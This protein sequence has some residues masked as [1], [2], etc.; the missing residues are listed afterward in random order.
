MCRQDGRATI[1]EIEDYRLVLRDNHWY[2]DGYCLGR[3]AFRMFRL[4]R[5]AHLITQESRFVSRTE[6]TVEPFTETMRKRQ[7]SIM[8]RIDAFIQDRVMDFCSSDHFTKEGEMHYLVHC[9]FIDDDYGYSILLSFGHLC[10]C[11]DPPAIR[12]ELIRRVGKQ[13]EI[14][15]Q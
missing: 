6:D 10:E 7:A 14:Y 15:A 13:Y 5:I 3:E 1:R 12:K 2:V 9:P 4:S 11:I 8:L